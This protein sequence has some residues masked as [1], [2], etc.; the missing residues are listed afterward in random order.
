M[1]QF[2]VNATGLIICFTDEE[3]NIKVTL[4]VTEM[5]EPNYLSETIRGSENSAEEEFVYDDNGHSY[6]VVVY[7]S[8]VEGNVEVFDTTIEEEIED[9]ECE[10]ITE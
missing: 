3:N 5:P 6:R 9:F 1:K 8:S 7:K 4:Q 10:E 2:N